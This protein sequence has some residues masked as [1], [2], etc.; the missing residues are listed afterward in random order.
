M[1]EQPI[2]QPFLPIKKMIYTTRIFWPTRI[3][4]RLDEN[5]L[6]WRVEASLKDDFVVYYFLPG[7]SI[8]KI[9]S[10]IFVHWFYQL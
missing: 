6:H 5:I 8:L 2:T 10:T 9:V 3:L 7:P 4:I 1:W